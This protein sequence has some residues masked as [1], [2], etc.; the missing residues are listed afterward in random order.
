MMLK[1]YFDQ[2][3][4]L[5]YSTVWRWHF[6][7]GLFCIPFVVLLSI[8][9]AIYLFK[10][11]V[12]AFQYRDYDHLAINGLS[13]KPAKA[14]VL[15]A[16][17]S[18]PD[19]VFIAYQLPKT[20]QSAAQ[21]ML[22][23]ND[24]LFRVLVNPFSLQVLKIEREENRLMTFIHRLHGQ[25]LLGERG[26]N[27]VELAASWA[28]VMIIT[29][30]FLWW[31]RNANKVAGILYPRLTKN[32]I[33]KNGKPIKS[34]I[35]WRDLHAVIGFWISFFTLLLLISGLPWTKSWGGLLKDIRQTNIVSQTTQPQQDWTIGGKTVQA[36]GNAED[37]HAQHQQHGEHHQTS[38]NIDALNT[39]VANVAALNL[40]QPVLIVAPSKKQSAWIAKSDAQNRPLRVSIDL[41]A[42]S[43]EILSRKNFADRPFLDRLIGYGIAIHEGQLF[44][45]LNQLLGL[46]TALG[47]VMVSVSGTVMWWRKRQ[48][49]QLGAPIIQTKQS[50]RLPFALLVLICTF[51]I[52]LP[53]LGLSLLF[54]LAIEHW[55][56]PYFPKA[57][58]F[59]GLRPASLIRSN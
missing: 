31:P 12:E 23:K 18:V 55:I 58:Q 35:F 21:V 47:L 3:T 32:I 52:L 13:A 37:E 38:V 29:G 22:K 51:S 49:N 10:P 34:R 1:K 46:L 25:L 43:G 20:A 24:V 11:Q 56:L 27:I 48:K 36:A 30:L 33:I 59:L 2:A 8:T 9:G 53:F 19:T 7:A 4:A 45:W 54:I 42:N 5:H 6:Y 14:Q 39:M 40:A 41:D 44:G 26:S 50:I 57:V 16:I 15:A 17:V 28:I